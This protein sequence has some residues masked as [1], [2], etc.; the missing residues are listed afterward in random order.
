MSLTHAGK[1]MKDEDRDKTVSNAEIA[2]L[3]QKVAD[4]QEAESRYYRLSEAWRDLWAQY[5][6]MIEAFDGLYLY[7]LRE[8]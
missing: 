5:E 4:L 7:L 3:R 1:Q 6:A 8:L 2:T